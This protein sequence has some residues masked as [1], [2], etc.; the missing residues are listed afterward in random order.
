MKMED[1]RPLPGGHMVF[2]I[3]TAKSTRYPCYAFA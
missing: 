3:N 2:E 1:G